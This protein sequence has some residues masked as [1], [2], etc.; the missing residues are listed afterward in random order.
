MG[1][2]LLSRT[3]KKTGIVYSWRLFPIGGFVSM[4]GEDGES[5]DENAFH[6]KPVWQRIIITAAGAAVNIV[7]GIV[8]M[9]IISASAPA[10]GSTTVAE[11]I[12]E[13]RFTE[14]YS[15]VST[16]NEGLRVGDR[17]VK[18]GGTG[19]HILDEL[20]YEIMHKGGENPIDVTVIRDGERV[21]LE[22]V[23]FSTVE[24]QGMSFGIRDFS[25]RAENKTFASVF[26]HGF[27]RS[28]STVKM[29]WESLIDMLRGRYGI[30][31][32]SGP[33]GVTQM[34]ADAA[35]RDFS[36][37]VYLA[38]VISMN[39]GVMNLLPLPALDGGRLLFQ[40]IE[41]VFRRPVNRNVEGYIHFAGIVILMAFMI[42][43]AVKDIITL[44]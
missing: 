29:I 6:K 2:K 16:E 35:S 10:L 17:I 43:I 25:V 31:A 36:Q 13:D 9:V 23:R 38:V 21:K 28:V 41:L 4:D 40:V 44:I 3:S 1:P 15:Y 5:E 7:A 27:F 37:F 11:F 30:N 18:I 14:G 42:F 12:P 19:V 39:L 22:D 24:E 20:H 26:K 32:V 34:L 33:V 8:A